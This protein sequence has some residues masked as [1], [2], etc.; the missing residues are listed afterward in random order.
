MS[1]ARKPA[2][3]VSRASSAGTKR[4]L[5]TTTTAGVMVVAAAGAEAAEVGL[6]EACG[7]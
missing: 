2:R 5:R 6:A 4:Y 7:P 3:P 1:S